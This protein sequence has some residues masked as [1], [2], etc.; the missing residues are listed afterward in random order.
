MKTRKQVSFDLD[1]KALQKYFPEENWRKAYDVI[2]KYM[3]QNGFDWQQGSVY[4]SKSSKAN[5]DIN[6]LLNN[7]IKENKWLH[8]CMKDCVV[9]S[10]SKQYSQNH[11]FNKDLDIPKRQNMD[12]D[13]DIEIG[14]KI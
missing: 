11:L 8:K 5:K 7:L 10:I 4:V 2:K 1:T 14:L 13:L 6:I 12:K 3:K 9:S